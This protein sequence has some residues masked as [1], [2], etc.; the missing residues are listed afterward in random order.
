[1]Q[2]DVGPLDGSLMR[3]IVTPPG[4][5]VGCMVC[6]GRC[7]MH[8]STSPLQGFCERRRQ[9]LCIQSEPA[10][11]GEPG[12]CHL[13]PAQPESDGVE[14]RG[15][16]AGQG[17]PG[18]CESSRALPGTCRSGFRLAGVGDRLTHLAALCHS[19]LAT[20]GAR[21]LI[22]KTVKVIGALLVCIRLVVDIQQDG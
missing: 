6:G 8:G 22:C 13:A 10:V 11:E 15:D 16:G 20:R 18:A 17:C 4:E 14:G 12:R 9:S 2:V 7:A 5:S 19:S 1:M 3:G 21:L